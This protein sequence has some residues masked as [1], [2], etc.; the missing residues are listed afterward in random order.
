MIMTADVTELLYRVEQYRRMM[1]T[2]VLD[3]HGLNLTQW[4]ALWALW[5]ARACSMSELAQA[6][7]IERTSLT[8]AID[9]LIERNCVV[10][11]AL[12]G[13]RR[14][15]IVQASPGGEILAREVDAEVQAVER[16]MLSV[17]DQD[18]LAAFA[19]DLA[20]LLSSRSPDRQGGQGLSH[21]SRSA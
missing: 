21:R 4:M 16:Q 20:T 8:R 11:L 9:S 19:H 12:P 6:S 1:V 17:L 7:S 13:D 2:Q 18:R 5:R 15:V 3:G 14:A 10:R